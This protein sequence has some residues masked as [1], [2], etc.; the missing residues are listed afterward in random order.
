MI[1]R[2][3]TDILIHVIKSNDLN[4]KYNYVLTECENYRDDQNGFIEELL[5]VV[6][7][8]NEEIM[9]KQRQEKN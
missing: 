7:Q 2:E 9:A 8:L 6:N 1:L 3:Y 5:Y 4:E